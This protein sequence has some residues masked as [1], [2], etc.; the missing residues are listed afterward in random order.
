MDS[1]VPFLVRL[2]VGLDGPPGGDVPGA[3]APAA[4][5]ARGGG[6]SGAAL[7]FPTAAPPQRET[8]PLSGSCTLPAPLGPSPVPQTCNERTFNQRDNERRLLD[9]S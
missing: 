6:C 4:G 3:V 1:S 8:G 5:A 2:R 9:T 7:A